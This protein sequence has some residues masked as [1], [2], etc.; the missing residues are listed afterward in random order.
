MK[1][2]I[3]SKIKLFNY[4]VGLCLC[5][6][7]YFHSGL[8]A[9]HTPPNVFIIAFVFCLTSMAW[10][11][12]DWMINLTNKNFLIEHKSNYIGFIGYLIILWL[13]FA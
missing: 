7:S 8:E 5:I 3:Y 12:V 9:T 2:N 6:L 1:L 4:V 11:I 13:I 10:L